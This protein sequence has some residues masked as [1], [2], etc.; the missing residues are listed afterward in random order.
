IVFVDS[1]TGKLT[2]HE[3]TAKNRVAHSTKKKLL[4]AIVDHEGKVSYYEV[5]WIKT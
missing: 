5:D 4:I 3:F 2:W 1:E